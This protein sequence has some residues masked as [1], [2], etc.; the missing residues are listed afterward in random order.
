[1][2]RRSDSS[3]FRAKAVRLPWATLA[4]RQRAL[5][6]RLGHIDV[7]RAGPAFDERLLQL[8]SMDIHLSWACGPGLGVPRGAFTVWT[9]SPKD[10]P[11]RTKA[12]VFSDPVPLV[13]WGAVEAGCVVVTCRPL[14]PGQPV[15]VLLFRTGDDPDHVVA[16]ASLRPV[17]A[18]PV[19]LEVR[20]S[21]ATYA[22]V[23]N[24]TD[25]RV[26]VDPLD[27]IVNDDA[28]VPLELVGLPVDQPLAGFEYDTSDQGPLD[29]LMPPVDAAIHRLLRGGPPIGWAPVTEAGRAAPPWQAPDP[30][31][32]VEEVRRDLFPEL[33]AL[34]DPSV[35]EYQQFAVTSPRTV[36][37]PQQD[38]RTSSLGTTADTGP[39]PM[40]MLP[41]LSDPFLNLAC[42]FGASYTMEQ[43]DDVQVQ[44]G[45]CDFLV[46]AKY[47]RL[48]PPDRGG[49]EFAA[50]APAPEP[51]LVV[52]APT[53]LTSERAGLVGP[54][55]PDAPWRESVRLAWDRVP[56]AAATSPVTESALARFDLLTTG[57]AVSLLP[58]RD[59]GGDRPLLV[60]PDGPEG[61]TGNNRIAL[62]DGGQ[63]IPIGSGGR[64]LGYAVAVSDLHGIW[65]PWQDV[66]WNGDEPA[67]QP[68]RL[69]SVA[70]DTRY[71]GSPSCPAT[72]KAEVAVEWE[73][74]TPTQVDLVAIWFPMS[75]P[76]ATPPAGLSPDAV[77]PGGCFRR[78]LGFGFVG[79]TP[80]PSGCT[81]RPLSADG[82]ETVVPGPAQGDG[83]RRYAV[84]ADVPTL[85]F[86][87]T[88]RW[89]VQV[90]ARRHLLVGASP[91]PWSP[92]EPHP[93]RT[94]AASPVPVVP[95]PPPPLPGV[96]LGSTLDAQGCS[97]VRVAWSLPGGAD[98]RTCI[99]WEVNETSLRQ[100]AGL[101]PRAP[102][103]TVP[104]QRLVDLRTAYDAMTPTQRRAAFRRFQEVDGAD[105]TY[106][107]TLPKGSTDIHLF[108][109][110][111]MTRS[112]VESP[113]PDSGTPH[114][115]LQAVMAPRLRRPAP[116]LA[117]PSVAADGTVTITLYAAS[118][119]AVQRFRLHRTTSEE[120]ARDVSTMGPAFAEVAVTAV[121]TPADVDRVLGQP[122]WSATWTGTL[123]G[124]WDPWL[125][126]AVAVPVDTV[127]AKG[128][129]GLPSVASDVVPLVV[130]PG[131]PELEPLTAEVWGGGHRGVLVRSAT[132]APP[133]WL[134]AGVHRLDGTAGAE[135]VAVVA[136]PEVPRAPLTAPPAAASTTP[137][138]E[139]G[140]RVA[141]RSPL[142]LWFTRPV[143]ADP[144]DVL[145]R[146]VDPFGREVTRELTVPGWVE[147]PPDV[148]LELVDV[149]TIAG[150][151]VHVGIRTNASA[152]RRPPYV[153]EV[154]ASQ[155]LG[156]V[157]LP[158]RPP[159]FRE[160]F[161][162][163]LGGPVRAGGVGGGFRRGLPFPPVGPFLPRVRTLTG[164]FPFDE[165]P[166]ASDGL[167]RTGEIAVVRNRL[168][169]GPGAPAPYE[170]FIPL[171]GAVRISVGVLSPEGQRVTATATT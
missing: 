18:D 155:L 58:R 31:L 61:R 69:I 169:R 26:A 85:D 100:R 152:R 22:K 51:H 12:F 64:H 115:H 122:I 56:K 141:G 104:G 67:P 41:A 123:P 89:G 20:T 38:G 42:G 116:P 153:L 76:T 81:V 113:W 107:A 66:A 109:V 28:W 106:D 143:A 131:A 139:Q 6:R 59:A 142:A 103:S 127:P 97:H 137:I 8:R 13:T 11:K 30:K 53:G 111:T 112:G 114:E 149:F 37:P 49:A 74:R 159:P 83:G 133:R 60:T 75:S 132:T 40:L 47:S 101:T 99:I 163:G 1:M 15:A 170:A 164:T 108:L 7:D 72:L 168:R 23:V 43:M 19:T 165:I 140:D 57:P 91:T 117:R 162:G 126:R 10:A 129:R 70:L 171:T 120:A 94:S 158:D 95:L 68:T 150:R 92:G 167:P 124:R 5:L 48:A 62:V 78:D 36:D 46:T 80:V 3:L 147:P 25:I 17:N 32:L 161:P 154:V 29:R 82:T 65:S 73:E 110:T 2:A 35:R 128:E 34:Y 21:G 145:L 96:P 138:I 121:P 16:A 148:T 130:P 45:R 50:Y 44:V 84:V 55:V 90:W 52:P 93:A 156:P 9:R 135:G 119:I 4:A 14:D 77:T 79:D 86:G 105:R 98:V 33:P 134:P 102:D 160:R 125:L 63:E 118:D 71:A 24:G 87:S 151:G 136:L 146:L 88:G 54:V 27:R 157:V 39:W 166:W 144:V